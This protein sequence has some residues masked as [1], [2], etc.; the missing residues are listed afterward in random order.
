MSPIDILLV[1]AGVDV[2]DWMA[3]FAFSLFPFHLCAP[4]MDHSIWL[5][6]TGILAMFFQGGSLCGLGWVAVRAYRN[7]K[8]PWFI[9]YLVFPVGYPIVMLV[10]N[11]LPP[12][13]WIKFHPLG[14]ILFL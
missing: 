10:T 12:I 8:R 5:S 4:M 2:Y 13:I 1:I 6:G 3:L 14:H 11:S 9:R 7:D